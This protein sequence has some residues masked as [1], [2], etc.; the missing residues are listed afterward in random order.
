MNRIVGYGIWCW[1]GSDGWGEGLEMKM[2][3]KRE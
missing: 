1:G 2:E 3:L